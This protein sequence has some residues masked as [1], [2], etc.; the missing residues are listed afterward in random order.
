MTRS[1]ASPTV[2]GMFNT[3]VAGTDGQRGRG[4]A[5]L[6]Q[7]IAT[8][9]AARLL[10]VGVQD[11]FPVPLQSYV[12]DRAVFER[13]LHG[14]RD[15][16]APAAMTRIVI[17]ISPARALRRIAETEHAD[18]VVVGSRD[19]GHLQRL[20][21]GDGAMQILHGAPCAVAIVP[22]HLS[23]CRSL[24]RIGVGIDEAPES[25]VALKLAI[26]LAR[27][28][29]AQIQLL[30]VASEVYA[31]S[32]NIVPGASYAD[33]Y[34]IVL[35]AR[36]QMAQDAIERGMEL[37]A[38]LPASGHAR[39][40]D[41]CDELAMLG[42]DCDLLV[43]GSRRW[44]PVRR[45]ALGGTSEHVIRMATCPVLVAPRHAATEHDDEL[46]PAG[47]GVAI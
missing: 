23:P 34:P 29:G 37:C 21:S 32:A 10:L 22:D 2:R 36:T 12:H 24:Q 26:E 33:V 30:A 46:S 17:D 1:Q 13:E 42:A 31:G 40:G 14:V 11:E 44:G 5:S 35:E 18:L 9:T 6:A 20:T 25:A 4:A 45:L 27:R 7:V 3:I 28:S 43:L 16:L 41:P 39:R 19:H 15:E 8:A 47:A 38:G